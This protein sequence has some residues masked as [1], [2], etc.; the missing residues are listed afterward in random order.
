MVELGNCTIAW[1]E[2]VQIEEGKV[3]EDDN[4]K[5]VIS[6]C[7]AVE[8]IFSCCNQVEKARPRAGAVRNARRIL[9]DCAKENSLVS[10][11]AKGML[12]FG[13]PKA[14]MGIAKSVSVSGLEDEISTTQLVAAYSGFEEHFEDALSDWSTWLIAGN[15]G[16]PIDMKYLSARAGSL[17]TLI[18]QVGNST[19]RWSQA[20]LDENMDRVETCIANVM[21]ILDLSSGVAISEI[22]AKLAPSFGALGGT[23]D[24]SSPGV[25]KA[26]QGDGYQDGGS[27]SVE[28][29]AENAGEDR[30]GTVD[31]PV[32]D[33]FLTLRQAATQ[34]FG[35][36]LKFLD[37]AQNL[38]GQLCQCRK[39]IG[40][41]VGASLPFAEGE[42]SPSYCA[43]RTDQNISYMKDVR[44]YVQACLTLVIDW[45]KVH[46]CHDIF[47]KDCKYAETLTTFARLHHRLASQSDTGLTVAGDANDRKCVEEFSTLVKRFLDARGGPVYQQHAARFISMSV[48]SIVSASLTMTSVHDTVM[49]EKDMC[50]KLP[51]LIDPQQICSMTPTF[52]LALSGGMGDVQ[53]SIKW[54]HNVALQALTGFLDVTGVDKVSLPDE[55]VN[56]GC[57]V[58][59]KVAEFIL[60]VV[61]AAR[62]I[63]VFASLVH[64]ACLTKQPTDVDKCFGYVPFGL[65]V[66]K[67]KL[68][69]LD[70]VLEGEGAKNVER[71]LVTQDM[72]AHAAGR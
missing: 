46:G 39:E 63:G 55:L 70:V 64:S 62:D 1:K 38:S 59:S 2:A 52:A 33:S 68:S 69:A 71:L 50:D 12:S 36:T 48:T 25:V 11:V 21:N 5:L 49:K 27:A 13:G 43:K 28:V 53:L 9:Y 65:V 35:D 56:Q 58:E 15:D 47:T 6:L 40:A 22:A 37:G 51:L 17:Q 57:E 32:D 8:S 34:Q 41:R 26:E 72:T 61:C 10:E 31:G 18:A 20:S 30:D 54:E 66:L 16:K 4:V 23:I 24:D 19:Q 42:V 7:D 60:N 45:R 3:P 44:D 67:E 29:V 14:A